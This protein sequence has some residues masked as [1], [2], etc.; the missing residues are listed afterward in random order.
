MGWGSGV[1]PRAVPLSYAH[2]RQGSH[3]EEREERLQILMGVAFDIIDK[4]FPSPPLI[5]VSSKGGHAAW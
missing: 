5:M 1:E 3:Q 4:A 2:A